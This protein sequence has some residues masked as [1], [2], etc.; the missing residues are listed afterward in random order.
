MLLLWLWAIVATGSFHAS[1][2]YQGPFLLN[3]GHSNTALITG[4]SDY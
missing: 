1:A 4:L 3:P 2:P